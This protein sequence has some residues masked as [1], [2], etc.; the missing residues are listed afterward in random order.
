[1]ALIFLVGLPTRKS[2]HGPVSTTVVPTCSNVLKQIREDCT[3]TTHL[4][5]QQLGI[6]E[7]FAVL[8]LLFGEG[9]EWLISFQTLELIKANPCLFQITLDLMF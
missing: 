4:G 2:I 9:G 5:R 6:T 1:M 8:F 3:W 7:H